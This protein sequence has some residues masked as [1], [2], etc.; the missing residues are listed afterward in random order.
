[1]SFVST[2]PQ[3]HKGQS[4]VWLTPLWLIKALG[5]DFELD[6]CGESFHRTAN[7]VFTEE[8]LDKKWFG[9][10]WLNPPYS[11]AKIW[12]A[13]LIAHNYGTALLFNRMDTKLM[14]DVVLKA[15][16]VFFLEGR[17]KFLTKDLEEKHNAGTGSVLISFGYTP[18][19]SNLKGW[20]AK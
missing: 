5:D 8:G 3:N 11:E 19:Y 7:Q 20:K 12:I 17:I 16:S 13:K 2:D 4:D 18:D 9:K 15:S 6:P 10:V 1:M 14:Q